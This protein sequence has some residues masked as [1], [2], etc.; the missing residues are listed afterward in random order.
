MENSMKRVLVLGGSGFVGTTLCE[1]LAASELKYRAVSR[2]TGQELTK[3]DVLLRLLEEED[4]GVVVNCAAHVGSL[5]YVSRFPASV[6]VDNL[7]L[8][9]ALYDAAHRAQRPPLIVNPIANCAY[10]GVGEVYRE[11]A[12]WDG[13][14][15]E[16]VEAYGSTRRMLVTLSKSFRI[17]HDLRSLNLVVPNMYGPHDSADPEKAHALNA[18]VAKFVRAEQGDGRVSVWGT[19]SAIREWLYAGD[20]ARIV[21]DVLGTSDP[22]ALLGH[23]FVNVGQHHGVSVSELVEIIGSHFDDGITVDWDRSR[24]DGAPRKVMDDARFRSVFP[25]FAFTPLDAGISATVKYYRELTRSESRW[26]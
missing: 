1:L 8:L 7:R 6:V 4:I 13:P 20:F 14:L 12:F 18:L 9:L 5:S 21:V 16:T 25:D 24:P 26:R 22:D 2:A 19:G 11:E 10:P 23:D 15:H 17:E 3:S